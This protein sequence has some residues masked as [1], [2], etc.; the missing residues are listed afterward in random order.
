[1]SLFAHSCS[2]EI[3]QDNL[4]KLFRP[5]NTLLNKCL[6][7]TI[8]DLHFIS[9][10]CQCSVPVNNETSAVVVDTHSSQQQSSDVSKSDSDALLT[11]S[12]NYVLSMF[13]VVIVSCTVRAMRKLNCDVR[14]RCQVGPRYSGED[15][16]AA[17]LAVRNAPTA[18]CSQI[19]K[20]W[21]LSCDSL[22]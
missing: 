9:H 8:D 21:D 5:K 10:P 1:M 15:P 6:E 19:Q 11:S 12:T 2:S 14:L 3:S 4:A 16:V 17:I 13:T 20:R 7:L 18:V 22:C